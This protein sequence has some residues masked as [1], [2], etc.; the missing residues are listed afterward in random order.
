MKKHFRRAISFLLAMVLLLPT[1]ALADAKSIYSQAEDLMIDGKWG[2]A[3]ALFEKITSYGDAAKCA[4]YCRA[5]EEF[6][7]GKLGDA[8]ATFEYLGDFKD[9]AMVIQYLWGVSYEA[10]GLYEKA[11]EAF[12]KNPFYKDSKAH[13]KACQELWEKEKEEARKKAAEEAERQRKAAEEAERQ[14]KAAEERE[15]HRFSNVYTIHEGFAPVEKDGKWGSVDMTGKQVIPCQGDYFTNFREGLARVK[16]NGKYGFVDT[17]GK[18]V[19][20]CQYDS[21]WDFSEGFARVR[22]GEK[23]G[24]V[25]KNG[26]EVIPCEYDVAAYGEGYFALIKDEYLTI[27]DKNL[28]RVF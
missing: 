22:K 10:S 20:P 24:F 11:I 18:V 8:I 26:K 13:I 14:R 7:Q 5:W 19:I 25:D 28:N 27:L 9:C 16:K 12:G 17:T 23:T 4:V 6:E 2:E 1:V 15:A 3:A 21:T